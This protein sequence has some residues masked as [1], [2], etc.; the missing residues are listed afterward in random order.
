M[1]PEDVNPRNFRWHHILYSDEDFS[2]A[3]GEWTETESLCVAMRWNESP[4]G[5]VGFPHAFGQHPMWFVLTDELKR[6]FLIRLLKKCK[7][8]K[9][10]IIKQIL[11]NE[12]DKTNPINRVLKLFRGY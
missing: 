8:D 10:S 6:G 1:K 5:S 7:K 3:Y 11:W 12:T 4:N 9:R 2:V